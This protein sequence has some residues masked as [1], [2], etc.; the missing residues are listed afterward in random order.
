[1]A[2]KKPQSVEECVYFTNRTIDTGRTMAW[3]FRKECP[4]CKKGNLRIMYNR[5]SRRYFVACS[6]YPDCKQ[7]YSL[8]PNALIKNTGKK[9]ES[10]LPLLMAIRKGK[11]PWEFPFNPNWKE[12]QKDKESNEMKSQDEI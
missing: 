6:A 10:G 1:M 11:R 2:L 9:S 3:V 12:E 7:T 8:P 4:T 5:A